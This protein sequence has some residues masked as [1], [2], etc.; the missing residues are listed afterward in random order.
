MPIIEWTEKFSINHPELDAQHKK[1]VSI[2]NEAHDRMMNPDHK[3][4]TT[5]G[6]DALK[7]MREYSK[8]HFVKE[9]EV[10]AELEMPDLEKHKKIH[11]LF[12]IEIEK[13]IQDLESGNHV[14]N[15]EVIKRLENWL[16]QHILKEDFK[17]KDLI[18]K[19]KAK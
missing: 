15:S 4:F 16:R 12:S 6:I 11:A 7:E 2:Y 17:L 9:E 10:M 5:T 3:G 18:D 13:M 19:S 14:L 1:W 8:Y